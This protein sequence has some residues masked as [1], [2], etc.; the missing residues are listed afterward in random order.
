M[1]KVGAWG[2]VGAALLLG[3]GAATAATPADGGPDRDGTADNGNWLS[4]WF[5]PKPKP[6]EKKPKVKTDKE[7][8]GQPASVAKASRPLDDAAT[9]RAREEAKYFRRS[10][11]C[12]KLKDIADQTNDAAL[13][14][15]AEQMEERAWTVYLE[16]TKHLA[17]SHQVFESDQKTLEK[18]LGTGTAA[19]EKPSRSAIYTVPGKRDRSSA[20]ED[21]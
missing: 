11:V 6:P 19:P 9:Q 3:A 8:R 13:R 7:E 5:Q 20:R 21:Q 2:M 14:Q 12:G 17:S 4:R 1:H 16:H 18:H 10:E 15:Q